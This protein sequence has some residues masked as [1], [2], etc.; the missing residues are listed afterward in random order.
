MSEQ[1]TIVIV[2]PT[3]P[4]DYT[5]NEVP[6]NYKCGKCGKLVRGGLAPQELD[7][8]AVLAQRLENLV[9]GQGQFKRLLT[10]IVPG[11][12]VAV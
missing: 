3:H 7:Q 6:P 8:G 9:V 1:A 11:G 10:G 2:D 12:D 5:K 4:V